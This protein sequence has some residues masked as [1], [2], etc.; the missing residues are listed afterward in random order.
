MDASRDSSPKPMG[1][2]TAMVVVLTALALASCAHTTATTAPASDRDPGADA[3]ADADADSDSDSDSD[4]DAEADADSD[5]DSDADSEADSDA[6]VSAIGASLSVLDDSRR[7]GEL[8]RARIDAGIARGRPAMGACVA[9]S[10]GPD[11]EGRLVATFIIEPDGSVESV[12]FLVSTLAD[13]TLSTCLLDAFRGL[14]FEA[15][16]GGIVMVSYPFEFRRVG[17]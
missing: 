3:D 14:R 5:S 8:P 6:P 12:A 15:P 9:A 10:E 16:R 4:A 7:R 13:D 17:G 11:D 2:T 1:F